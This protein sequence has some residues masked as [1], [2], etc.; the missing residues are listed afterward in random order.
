MVVLPPE[1]VKTRFPGYFWSTKKKTLYS[2]KVTG[3]LR[4]L[5]FFKGGRYSGYDLSPGYRIS[6]KGV[7][8]LLTMEYLNGLQPTVDL[9]EIGVSHG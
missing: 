6:H 9:Q 5:V 4:P 7:R 2:I 3:E 8:H 1:F